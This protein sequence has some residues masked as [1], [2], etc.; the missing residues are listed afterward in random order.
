MSKS[1]VIHIEADKNALCESAKAFIKDVGEG[2][3]FIAA[4][5]SEDGDICF[6]HSDMRA[7][8]AIGLAATLTSYFTDMAREFE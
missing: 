3:D 4:T 2:A 8:E 6:W 1:K 5:L 7:L